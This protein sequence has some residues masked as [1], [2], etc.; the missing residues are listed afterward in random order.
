MSGFD[1]DPRWDALA[2]ILTGHATGVRPGDRVL[3]AMREP[4]VVPLAAAVHAAAV[5]AGGY[6]QTLLTAAAFDRALLL[7]GD[8]ADLAREPDLE[9]LAYEWADVAI[10]LR[11]ARNPHEFSDIPAGRIATHR[12]TQG[13]IS[14]LRTAATRWTLVRIPNEAFAQQAGMPLASAMELFFAACLR[15]WEADAGDWR[16]IARRLERGS[17]VAI[18]GP[19][20]DLR[21]ST[22]GRRWV[23]GDGRINIPDGEIYTAPAEGSLEGEI[24]FDW[25]QSWSGLPVEDIRLRF[26]GGAVAEASG[27]A[28]PSMPAEMPPVSFDRRDRGGALPTASTGAVPAP[29]A[30][31]GAAGAPAPLSDGEKALLDHVR[32]HEGKAEV[33]CIVRPHG[34]TQAASEV[35]VLEGSSRDFVEHL[36]K[37]HTGHPAHAHQPATPRADL[38]ALPPADPLR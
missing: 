10:V 23:V 11:G 38:A 17:V 32:Q 4:D 21:F 27:P 12:A 20:V 7:N 30:M 6:P 31:A 36:S 19:G 34:A 25:P 3:V 16:A 18:S 33:I 37:A 35:F 13:A 5:R 28:I 26:A 24:R 2:A 15:D 1:H 9:R 29:V 8:D 14:A 22:A